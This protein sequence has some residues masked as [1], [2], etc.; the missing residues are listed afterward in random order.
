ML[1]RLYPYD[2]E[3][4]PLLTYWTGRYVLVL[5]LSLLVMA[6]IAGVWIRTNTY[7]HRF[8]LL[9]LMAEHLADSGGNQVSN[10]YPSPGK[11]RAQRMLPAGAFV[12]QV[13][14]RSGTFYTISDPMNP[15][16]VPQALLQPSPQYRVVLGGVVTREQVRT[17]TQTWLRVGVPVYDDSTLE[18]VYVLAPTENLT[19]QLQR[20][21][22]YL[23]IITATIGLAGWLVLYFLSRR[24]TSPVLRVAEAAQ[25]IARGEYQPDL[26]GKLREKELQQLVTSFKNMASQLQELEKM[27]SDLLAGISHELRTPVTSIR[28][29]IQGVRDKVVSGAEAEEFLKISMDEALRLQRMV[30]ELLDLSSLEAGAVSI[31][32]D[33]TD[34]AAL[35]D[36]VA[37]QVL[38]MDEFAGVGIL[39]D[40]PGEP[41]WINCDADRVRQIILNLFDNSRKA[42]AD[43]IRVKLA[44]EG[45]MALLDV[46]DNGTGISPEE[47]RYVFERFFRGSAGGRTARGL[48]LGLT[49]SRLLA[50]AHGGDLILLKTG[51]GGTAFRLSLLLK[52][53]DQR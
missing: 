47:E 43:S 5:L 3:S 32:K 11:H 39:K 15:I 14:D 28:G 8:E 49:V 34:L 36:E 35:V 9:Q 18:A 24:L 48:G 12:V 16:P 41:L 40:L 10:P 17:G 20:L 51:P 53:N 50:R 29:M 25:S 6:V 46:E 42:N 26:P 2:R 44:E 38:L 27:R 45:G 22:G 4:V 30:E 13:V 37:R 19:G 23:A 1:K 31:L 52:M 21:Y 7:N 33:R